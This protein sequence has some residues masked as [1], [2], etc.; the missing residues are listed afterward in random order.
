MLSEDQHSSAFVHHQVA[1]KQESP[2]KANHMMSYRSAIDAGSLCL[3]QVVASPHSSLKVRL[4]TILPIIIL[5]LVAD[6]KKQHDD[7]IDFEEQS[8]MPHLVSRRHT[9]NALACSIIETHL[10]SLRKHGK[11]SAHS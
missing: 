1:I 11:P 2:L 10:F 5:L 6:P 3:V 9:R 8:L 4:E 7:M